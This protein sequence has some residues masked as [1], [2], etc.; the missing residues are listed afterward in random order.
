MA[1]FITVQNCK[2]PPCLPT[3]EQTDNLWWVLITEQCSTG[4]RYRRNHHSLE[5]CMNL[6]DNTEGERPPE[7][8]PRAS[9]SAELIRTEGGGRHDWSWGRVSGG[10]DV[11]GR[12]LGCGNVQPPQLGAVSGHGYTHNCDGLCALPCMNITMN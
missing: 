7:H 4:R 11:G 2:Q 9:D 6:P 8:P 10:E 3:D 1:A 12:V 5:S